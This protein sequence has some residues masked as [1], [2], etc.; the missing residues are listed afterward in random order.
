M[1]P[2]P[3]ICC[4][5]A[6]TNDLAGLNLPVNIANLRSI[7]EQLLAVKILPIAC[8][9]PTNNTNRAHCPDLND[10]IATLALEMDL[11]FCDF[12]EVTDNGVDGWIENYSDDGIHPTVAGAKVMGQLVRDTID[13]R[14]LNIVPE[15]ITVEN[16]ESLS[17]IMM[18]N[19][20][21]VDDTDADG[22]PNGG[23][24]APVTNSWQ[25]FTGGPDTSFSLVEDEGVVSGKWW[26]MNKT[27]YTANLQVWQYD[28]V[29]NHLILPDN[30]H[31]GFGFM[32]KVDAVGG[33]NTDI[34][35]QCYKW[36]GGATAFTLALKGIEGTIAPFV[37]YKPYTV[38]VGFS[39]A[40]YSIQINANTA[41]ISIGQL[42]TRDLDV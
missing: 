32:F 7:Y 13:P 34:V 10:A 38:P 41:D 17:G 5:L 35:L 14:L 19:G 6:G 29:N 21:M 20:I 9:V 39:T 2:L 27:A 42:T 11:P 22:K 16:E 28:S 24:T 31:M 8:A 26:R 15:L 4:V 12:F 40:R 1:N 37:F 30:H 3:G 25:A 23:C 33:I 36:S 18:L